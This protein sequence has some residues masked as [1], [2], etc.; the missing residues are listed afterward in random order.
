MGYGNH[1]IESSKAFEALWN[2]PCVPVSP[3]PAAS[4]F[5]PGNP[6][7]YNESPP[8]THP[9]VYPNTAHPCS[10]ILHL[11]L[12]VL[13][14]PQIL[15]L[16]TVPLTCPQSTHTHTHAFLTRAPPESPD[17]HPHS[18]H[19]PCGIPT[20]CASLTFMCPQRVP[21]HTLPETHPVTQMFSN[22]PTSSLR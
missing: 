15:M 9:Y 11:P 4:A 2:S 19:V 6:S 1:R 16:I 21:P 17:L 3:L 13:P 10:Y 20:P 8:C 22:R 18:S 7:H 12:C 14:C 5:R